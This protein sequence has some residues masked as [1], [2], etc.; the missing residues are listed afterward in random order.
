MRRD[1]DPSTFLR[2]LNSIAFLLGSP[3]INYENLSPVSAS[4]K[5]CEKLL[6]VA[7]ACII[8]QV[9]RIYIYLRSFA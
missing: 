6:K 9:A 3:C 2:H 4:K 8:E 7:T 1:L 5:G